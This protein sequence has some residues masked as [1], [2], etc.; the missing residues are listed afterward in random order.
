MFISSSLKY[1]IDVLQG[2]LMDYTNYKQKNDEAKIPN[3]LNFDCCN[4]GHS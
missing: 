1:I 4:R 2:D 3:S